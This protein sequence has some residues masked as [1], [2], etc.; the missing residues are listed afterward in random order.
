[1]AEYKKHITRDLLTGICIG[2]AATSI[3]GFIFLAF[4]LLK[5]T[6][7]ISAKSNAGIFAG[8]NADNQAE[9][10]AAAQPS[11]NNIYQQPEAGNIANKSDKPIVELFVMS[12][13][14]YGTQIEKGIIP[15]IETLGNKVDF[16]LKFVS[17]TMHGEKEN[18]ENLRQYCLQKEQKNK[19]F[20]YLKC[21]LEA[22]D[23][24]GCL[25]SASVEE[26]KLKSCMD[27]TANNFNVTGTNFDVYKSDNDKYG[28]Q[29]SPT[30]VIN[31]AISQ[32]G[33]DS[34][35]LLKAICSAFDNA[36]KECNAVLSSATP[37]PGF[38]SGTAPSGGSG[39]G[40]GQ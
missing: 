5:T 18:Q 14:P 34:N 4:T 30:L 24:A 36:P 1:M 25:N 19:L 3:T 9:N 17:Y 2:V 16:N 7:I 38:G 21:F 11:A 29:G 15:T 6:N 22:S 13:C 27:S 10:E 40:C 23:S 37:A 28:V 20:P 39:S 33:R 31:G 8:D 12:Y 35:S 32:S 26:N